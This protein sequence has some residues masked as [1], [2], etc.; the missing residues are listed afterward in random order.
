MRL[1]RGGAATESLTRSI[2]MAAILHQERRGFK[3]LAEIIR[4]EEGLIVL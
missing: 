2:L 4:G 3:F 1:T